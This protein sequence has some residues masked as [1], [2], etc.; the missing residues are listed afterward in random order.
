MIST[1]KSRDLVEPDH[2]IV[3]LSS[4]LADYGDT[5]TREVLM[6]FSPITDS[7]PAEFLEKN[8]ITMEKR[9]LSRTYIAFGTSDKSVLGFFTVGMKC[10]SIPE[11]SILS[12]NLLRQCNIDSST[13]VAQSF[14]LGQPARSKASPKGFGDVLIDHA[15]DI[16]REAKVLVG[17]RMLRLDCTDDL[18]P[19]Y[20]RHGFTMIRKNKDKDLNQ[21]TIII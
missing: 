11:G 15:V 19:Y 20:E 5:V 4:L 1:S 12:R 21:M 2:A 3:P 14:L 10:V 13:G 8:A 9:D 6:R 18:V 7:S 16:V 17:C